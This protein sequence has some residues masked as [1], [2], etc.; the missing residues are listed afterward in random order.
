VGSNRAR[1]EREMEEEMR[2]HQEMEA[3]HLIAHGAAPESARRRAMMAFG[4]DERFKEEAREGMGLRWLSDFR[5]DTAFALRSLRRS[6]VFTTVAVAAL[7]I[8]IGANATVFGLVDSVAFR[9]LPVRD[10]HQLVAVFATQGD[11]ALQNISYQSFEDLRAGVSSFSDAAA[12]S[13]GSVSIGTNAGPV[14]AWAVQ[15]S[16]NYFTLLGVEAAHG[17]LIRPGDVRNPVAVISDAFWKRQFNAD[18]RVVGRSV[19]VNGAVY[20]FESLT[21][22]CISRRP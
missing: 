4:G 7:G 20:A 3:A 1:L 2:F 11:A 13:E 5:L 14:V 22:S 15:A 6:P 9:K 16:D 19:T 18:P 21:V 17:R 10:P 12:F 8:G